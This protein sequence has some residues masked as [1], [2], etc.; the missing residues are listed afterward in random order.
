MIKQIKKKI[1]EWLL[2]DIDYPLRIGDRTL[3]LSPDYIAIKRA[4][5]DGYAYE[6]GLILHNENPN[7]YNSPGI[8]FDFAYNPNLK[9]SIFQL[10]GEQLALMLSDDGGST[11]VSGLTVKKNEVNT[12][13]LL[14]IGTE[15][16][17]IGSSTRKYRDM[18]LS[19]KANTNTFKLESRTS[20][21][22]LEKGL[23]WFRGDLGKLYYSPDGSTKKEIGVYAENFPISSGI[24]ALK[25]IKPNPSEAITI[26]EAESDGSGYWV[27]ASKVFY[28]KET[29]EFWLTYRWRNP[30][31]RGYKAVIAKSTDGINFT[32][33]WSANK[34]DFASSTDSLE[35]ASLIRHPITGK[36][37]YYI[38]LDNADGSGDFRIYK[39][40]DVDD[41]TELDPSTITKVLDVGVSGEWD[42]DMVKDPLVFS[43]GGLLL[44]IYHGR[45]AGGT[46]QTG[47]AYSIDGITWTKYVNNPIIRT[48][49]SG[50]WDSRNAVGEGV[51]MLDSA[52]LIYYTG[53]KEGDPEDLCKQG[54]VC[55]IPP[56]TGTPI[57]LTPDT[58]FAEG[59]NPEHPSLKYLDI[60]I[61]NGK[62]YLYY[63]HGQPDGS[64][65]LVVNIIDLM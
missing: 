52:W 34:T 10:G 18:Y 42:D 3:E 55:W 4:T 36:Y 20:D 62:A 27:G 13:H 5:A 44:M 57:K 19:G 37:Q 26:R 21:P 25:P 59:I 46:T 12:R 40:A 47:L 65:D 51:L 45:K 41:P 48:G 23:I 17:D 56:L 7:G 35:L 28:D 58:P 2:K 43:V 16:Y 22:T 54:L 24:L 64:H 8:L 9:A 53:R 33:V 49:S 15:Q 38:C 32:D 31:Q 63:E 29:G 50:A 60:V 11:W 14:P 30:T 39:L 6:H 61:I 1:L